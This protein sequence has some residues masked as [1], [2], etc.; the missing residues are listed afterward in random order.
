MDEATTNSPF[1]HLRIQGKIHQRVAAMLHDTSP[2]P[3]P[4][5][6]LEIHA[7]PFRA[8]LS[9]RGRAA[10]IVRGVVKH[11]TDILRQQELEVG[12]A[13]KSEADLVQSHAKKSVNVHF[14]CSKQTIMK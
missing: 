11:Q 7:L 5:W 1:T 3:I 4:F 6:L 2:A 12:L 8:L 10:R 9:Q 14:H 13:Q